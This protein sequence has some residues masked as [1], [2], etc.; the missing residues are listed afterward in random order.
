LEIERC[1][2]GGGHCDS[3][4]WW[5]WLLAALRKL[6]L[7]ILAD[8]VCGVLRVVCANRYARNAFAANRI[9]PVS[10]IVDNMRLEVTQTV[11]CA[12]RV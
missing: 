6:T 3:P 12:L 2:G 11:I 8:V 9:K 5:W 4:L 1:G 7:T 10:G